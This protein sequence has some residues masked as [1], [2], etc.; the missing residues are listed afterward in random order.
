[1]GIGAAHDDVCVRAFRH[2]FARGPNGGSGRLLLVDDTAGLRA[3][4]FDPA[5]PARTSADASVLDNVY[6]D[7]STESRGWLAISNNGT[8]VYAF[9]NPSKTSLV[10]VDREGKIEPCERA[11]R[12]S[13]SQHLAG[14]GE[15]RRQAGSQPL[16]S[17]LQA[18][19]PQPPD[20]RASTATF[21]RRGA[22]TAGASCSRRIAAATGTS[23]RSPP[24]DRV[25]QKCC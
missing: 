4:P 12:V 9:G 11:G 13:G 22:P 10:W 16:D 20:I 17:R 6:S 23:T 7:I 25:Q 24:T 14:R 21:F 2:V 19:D 3:A 15:S 18:R 1:M 8:A 5:R